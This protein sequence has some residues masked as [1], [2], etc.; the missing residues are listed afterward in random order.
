M[1]WELYEGLLHSC[2]ANCEGQHYNTYET[3]NHRRA[4]KCSF[5]LMEARGSMPAQS[6]TSAGLRRSLITGCIWDRRDPP[7]MLG[8]GHRYAPRHRVP[9]PGA[10]FALRFKFLVQTLY[11]FLNVAF[12]K[13]YVI[14]LSFSKEVIP[15][16]I[17]LCFYIF[18]TT[19]ACGVGFTWWLVRHRLAGR[20]Q[21]H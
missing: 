6:A 20:A 15:I 21:T 4:F 18:A 16:P 3:T 14:R 13:A 11:Y 12:K 2:L 1:P 5:F 10:E 7:Q 9:K 8:Q 19:A 17:Y